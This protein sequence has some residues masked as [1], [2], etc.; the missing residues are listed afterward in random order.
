MH[1]PF[2]LSLFFLGVAGCGPAPRNDYNPPP[3]T[4]DMARSALD[5]DNRNA[6]A[7][8]PNPNDCTEVAGCYT[9]YA[10]GDHVLYKIDLANK[11]LVTVGNFNAPMVT[12]PNGKMAED[13]VT[14]IAVAPD[15]TIYGIS[16]EY[17]YRVDAKDA[18]VTS[19]G[20]VT[21][22]GQDNV[23]LTTTPDGTL[24]AA[25]FKGAFCKID[26]TTR[27]P[28]VKVVG[29]LGGNL[30]VSGDLVAVK[31]GTIF[32]TAYN[33]N[34][35]AT[36]MNNTLIKIDPATGRAT[37][38]IG[39][40]GFPRLYGAAFDQGVVFGFT[41]DGSGDVITIDPKTGK[42]S[43]YKTFTDPMTNMGISFAGAGVNSMVQAPPPG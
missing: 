7:A 5:L 6:D 41:H 9:V 40:T 26:I 29:M 28:T 39:A 15:N 23:A 19:I 1:R 22:C 18:H 33:L 3:P 13:V 21:Q 35:G 42:G 43:L 16:H 14:D 8:A 30:A 38:T 25:D 4:V 2:A 20:A 36:Q 32:A 11:S 17:L 37:Q 27:P 12:L 24:Y 10:H 31:D 34:N